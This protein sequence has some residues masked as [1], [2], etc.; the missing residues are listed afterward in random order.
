MNA[1][2]IN[3]LAQWLSDKESTC[4]A[5]DVGST[6]GRFPGGRRSNPLQYSCQASPMTLVPIKIHMV[7][8]YF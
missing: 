2:N 1:K 4:N 5:G 6:P 3:G 7:R 8:F